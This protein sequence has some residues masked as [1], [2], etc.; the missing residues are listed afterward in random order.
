MK[1]PPISSKGVFKVLFLFCVDVC[2]DVR[3]VAG[4]NLGVR[5]VR[6]HVR[7]TASNRDSGGYD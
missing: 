1:E 6:T 7:C 5:L 3:V 4:T 2:V